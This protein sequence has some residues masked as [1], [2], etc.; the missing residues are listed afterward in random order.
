DAMPRSAAVDA[1]EIDEVNKLVRTV[2]VDDAGAKPGADERQV[3]VA[4]ARLDAPLLLR[5]L[6][7]QMQLV[8]PIP[9]TLGKRRLVRTQVGRYAMA[10]HIQS[11][12]G[13]L[14]E[15][16]RGGVK[17]VV[18]SL[19]KRL[20]RRAVRL[21]QAASYVYDIESGTRTNLKR[22][23]RLIDGHNSACRRPR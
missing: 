23:F 18:E 10:S 7:A 16:A 19:R 8:M 2:P 21:E 22:D 14:V 20:Q 9:R 5:E 13:A 6:A 1:I 12:D 17:R 3:R 15:V 4:V 11:P